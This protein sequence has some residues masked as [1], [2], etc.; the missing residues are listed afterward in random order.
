[1]VLTGVG[2]D[3]TVGTETPGFNI[4][5]SDVIADAAI[6]YQIWYKA[7]VL[8]VWKD[9]TLVY[10]KGLRPSGPRNRK[11]PPARGRPIY[12]SAAQLYCPGSCGGSESPE[13]IHLYSACRP[14]VISAPGS[15]L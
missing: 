13:H 11:L 5:F 12:R 9:G 2:L 6:C 7:G 4:T 10:S 8:S 1:M 15:P 14:L 3:T